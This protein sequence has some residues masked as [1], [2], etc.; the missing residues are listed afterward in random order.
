VPAVEKIERIYRLRA[1]L[2]EMRNSVSPMLEICNQLRRHDFA[3]MVSKITPYLHDVHD[4]VSMVS[5]SIAD[6]RERLTAAFE[7]SLLL[8]SAR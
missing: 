8:A 5:E 3:I 1:G 4:H 7:A 6:L 2:L